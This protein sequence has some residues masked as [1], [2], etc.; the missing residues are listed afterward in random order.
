[1]YIYM[2]YICIVYVYICIYQYMIYTYILHI[3]TYIYIYIFTF[4]NSNSSVLLISFIYF[5]NLAGKFLTGNKNFRNNFLAKVKNNIKEIINTD[6]LHVNADKST[7]INKFSKE[8]YKKT[9]REI[10]M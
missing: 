1:M 3:N 10:F 9:M 8:Q 4:R 6:E 7:N 5:F 2:L